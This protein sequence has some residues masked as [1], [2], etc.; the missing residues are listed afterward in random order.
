M[1]ATHVKQKPKKPGHK[2]DPYTWYWCM[3]VSEPI[4]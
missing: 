4:S 1:K 2:R 3:H